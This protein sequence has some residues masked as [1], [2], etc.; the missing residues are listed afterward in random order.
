VTICMGGDAGVY[1]HGYNAL[2]MELMVEYGMAPV[3]VLRAATS[4]NARLFH[5]DDTVGAIRPGLLADL[6]AVQGDPARDITAIRR[7]EW[8][9]KDG[10]ILTG[11]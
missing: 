3:D 1:D 9:M 2:E 8:L 11:E 4:V 5:I 7:V 10:A 6:L